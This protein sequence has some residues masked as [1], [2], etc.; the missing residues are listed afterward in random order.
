VVHASAIS[1]VAPLLA[2]QALSETAVSQLLTHHLS[3]TT[4]MLGFLAVTLAAAGVWFAPATRA[5]TYSTQDSSRG[6]EP[7]S[8]GFAVGAASPW[9]RLFR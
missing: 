6:G 9:R 7:A 4:L 1:I 8:A 5:D 2:V 3:G